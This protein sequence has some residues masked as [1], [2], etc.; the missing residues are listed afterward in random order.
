MTNTSPFLAAMV[1]ALF[2]LSVQLELYL[3]VVM[4]VM[5]IMVRQPISCSFIKIF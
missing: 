4:S 2:L 5:D 1:M 3:P